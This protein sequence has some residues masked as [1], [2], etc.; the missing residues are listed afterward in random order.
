MHL[1]AHRGAS[2]DAPENTLA[3]FRLGWQQD[4]D[5]IE[6]DFH[7]TKDGHIVCMH[8]ATTER[9]GDRVAIIAQSTLAELRQI[10]IGI[11]KGPQWKGERIPTLDEVL[12]TVPRGKRV[13][14]EI[15]CGP[16]ILAPLE[17]ILVASGVQPEQALIIAFNAEIIAATKRCLPHLQAAW[18]TG[19]YVDE[20]TGGWSPSVEVILTTLERIGADGVDI[21]AHPSIGPSFVQRLAAARKQLHV[22]TVDTLE[23][24]Q[25]FQALG[26]ASLT[27]NRPGWLRPQLRTSHP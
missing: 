15:K 14:L 16:E 3:A 19:L 25:Q 5:G 20:K 9:V 26:A 17:R 1:I 4:A 23:V 2:H 11:K 21:V 12:A 8:D 18:L 7:L 22:W 10:D 6:G 24:A 27:T 13:Y